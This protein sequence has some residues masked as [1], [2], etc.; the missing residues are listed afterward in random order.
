[1]RLQCRARRQ[2]VRWQAFLLCTGNVIRTRREMLVRMLGNV[3]GRAHYDEN[4]QHAVDHCS[5]AAINGVSW[6]GWLKP[7]LR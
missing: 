1:M 6:V 4:M 5:F 3:D 7:A 2:E